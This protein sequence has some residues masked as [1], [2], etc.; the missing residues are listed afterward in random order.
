MQAQFRGVILIITRWIAVKTWDEPK[1]F[2]VLCVYKGFRVFDVFEVWWMS[3]CSFPFN[4]MF[5]KAT[6]NLIKAL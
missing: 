5:D 2:M 6:S 1:M 4:I 3:Q